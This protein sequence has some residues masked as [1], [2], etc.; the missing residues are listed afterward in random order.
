MRA[1]AR[2]LEG[3]EKF[4]MPTLKAFASIWVWV[5]QKIYTVYDYVIMYV[6]FFLTMFVSLVILAF[7]LS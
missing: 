6:L 4:K 1:S 7:R 2:L 5:D 3:Q